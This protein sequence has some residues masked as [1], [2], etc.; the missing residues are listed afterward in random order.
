ME[1]TALGNIAMQCIASG[2]IKDMWEA[3]RIIRNSTDIKEYEPDM[4]NAAAWDEAYSRFLKI[5]G[6]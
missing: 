3:R 2:E 4:V 1:A 6:E 5:I